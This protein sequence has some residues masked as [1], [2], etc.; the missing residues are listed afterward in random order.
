MSFLTLRFQP[1][2]WLW[3][4]WKG[5][6]LGHAH[7]TRRYGYATNRSRVSTRLPGTPRFW[8]TILSFILSQIWIVLYTDKITL[9]AFS[10]DTSSFDVIKLVSIQDSANTCYVNTFWVIVLVVCIILYLLYFGAP[11]RYRSNGSQQNCCPSKIP[12]VSGAWW[13]M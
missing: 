10:H 1:F 13:N 12:L 5:L 6:K 11:C 7:K 9:Y 3:A 8:T 2:P 4:F